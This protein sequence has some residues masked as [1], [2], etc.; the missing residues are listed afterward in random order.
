M[1]NFR[2]HALLLSACALV[3]ASCSDDN[4]W[5]G[6]QGEGGLH[7]NLTT[8]GEVKDAIPMLRSQGE[9]PDVPDASQFAVTLTK[10]NDGSQFAYDSL[11]D[12]NSQDSF[13]AGS[14]TVG[15]NYGS[16]D[17]EGFESPYYYGEATVTVLEGREAS[18]DVTATLAHSMLSI[19]YSDAFKA[20][21]KDY[22][23]TAHS[24]GH[25][26]I[27]FVSA[28]TRPAYLAPGEV[29][30]TVHVTNPNGK[31]ADIQP[32]A[33]PAEARHHYHITFDVNNGSV[34]QAQLVITF[35]D[36]LDQED[37]FI[38]LTDELFTSNGPTVHAIG[39]EDGQ[40]FE[41]VSGAS[42][43]AQIRYNVSAPATLESLI[44]TISGDDFTP[45]FGNEI[46]LCAATEQQK[47]QI[48]DMGIKVLG[49]YGNPSALAYV[50]VTG[51][52]NH[53]PSGSFTV[54]LVAKDKYMRVSDPV[55][56]SFVTVPIVLDATPV[57]AVLN[58]G[59]ATVTV[60]YNGANPQE[61]ISFKALNRAGSYVDC[62]IESV[63]EVS[64]SR[65]VE[66]K[67]YNFIIKLPDTDRAEVPVRVY[68]ENQLKSEIKIEV[69][70]PQYGIAV[71]PFSKWMAIKVNPAQS[72]QLSMIT[73]GVKVYLN[74]SIVAESRIARNDQ[75]GIITVT[76]LEAGKQYSVYTSLYSDGAPGHDAVSF[77]SE[78]GANVPNGDFSQ[79][80]QTINI[81][82]INVGGPYTGTIFSAPTYQTTSSILVSEPT[83][84]ASVNAKTCYTGSS[85]MN[86]W[87]QV[88]STMLNDGKVAIRNVAYNHNGTTPSNYKETAKYYNGNAPTF[89]ND[90]K[91]AGE[92]F[93]G[94]YS[95]SG[96]ESRTDGIAFNCR[97]TSLSFDYSYA[98]NGSDNGSVYVA[99]LDASGN[100]LASGSA[101]LSS[102]SSM[103]TKTISLGNYNFG[104]RAAKLQV[105][106]LSSNAS[107]PPVTVPSGSALSEGTGLSNNKIGANTYHALATGSVLTI[108]NV[109]LNY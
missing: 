8:D 89:G 30:L 79:A 13:P 24:E 63:S 52:P 107:V 35:D 51:L 65:A 29:A 90:N 33:F 103:T 108:D 31:T 57:A 59:Q 9:A 104:S 71:D 4:P 101:I 42:L 34:G 83:G 94:E 2:N 15:A 106:F 12:F 56:V 73:S 78:S 72:N 91:C 62:P 19:D 61:A 36:T 109:T 53:L 81:D 26:Y 86:T 7:L 98:P 45:A 102:A 64:R 69:V 1:M 21:F 95:F 18:V 55:S 67:T 44:M 75:T 84:W 22:S 105:R 88:P 50:D 96:S 85:N 16:L 5:V 92:L 93:L 32:A 87:F 77:T 23:V 49:V 41:A 97:P 14:Y 39:F 43:P 60:D 48:A 40:V 82:P 46:D 100:V 10:N 66:T 17:N 37:V 25:N 99:V 11:D 58:S 3:L 28:E 76:G 20:Y 68:L 54:T 47:Q 74:G 6:P 27:D 70:A 38:D 80:N